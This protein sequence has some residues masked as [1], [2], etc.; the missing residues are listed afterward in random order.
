[1]R[2]C[3]VEDVDL[4][5]FRG[6]FTEQWLHGH[7]YSCQEALF[8]CTTCGPPVLYEPLRGG[9][10]SNGTK[11]SISYSSRTQ[12]KKGSSKSF[13]SALKRLFTSSKGTSKSD[14]TTLAAKRPSGSSHAIHHSNSSNNVA[15]I[16]SAQS[17]QMGTPSL[18]VTEGKDGLPHSTSVE[19]ELPTTPRTEKELFI[20]V[21]CGACY[22]R[23]HASHHHY[24]RRLNATTLVAASGA[25]EDLDNSDIGYPHHSFFF[26]VPSYISTRQNH[27]M[28]E[29]PWGLLFPKVV[30]HEVE[31]GIADLSKPLAFYQDFEEICDAS[32]GV[33]Q[34]NSTAHTRMHSKHSSSAFLE[35]CSTHASHP[36]P[37][38]AQKS[39]HQTS[40]PSPEPTATAGANGG[41]LLKAFGGTGV[42]SPPVFSSAPPDS[43]A[44]LM[45]CAKC[46]DRQTV[47]LSAKNCDNDS[48][49]HQHLRRLGQLTAL[50]AYFLLR[51]VQ[52]ELPKKYLTYLERR[53]RMQLELSR[54]Q[55]RAHSSVE[56]QRVSKLTESIKS[57]DEMVKPLPATS[58]PTTSPGF[59]SLSPTDLDHVL[60]RA[61]LCGFLNTSYF[62]YMNSVLQC[63]LRCRSFTA[64]LMHLGPQGP[65]GELTSDICHLVTHVSKQTYQD[66]KNCAVH[67]F[68]NALRRQIGHLN[69]LF[70]EGEQQD[71]QEF[72][73]TLLNGIADE[74]DKG[75]SDAEKKELRRV[76]FEGALMS[77]AIC[78]KCHHR[79]PRTEMF[80]SLSIPIEKSIEEGVR[81]LFTPAKLTGK[82]CY[83]CETCFQQMP[84]AAQEEHNELA[85]K[86]TEEIKRA[87]AAGKKATKQQ[88]E[89]RVYANCLYEEAEVRTSISHLG[90]SLAVHLLR[91]HYDTEAQDFIKV[92]TPVR[93]S[94]TL[95]LRPYVTDEVRATYERA[96]QVHALRQRFP[97]V[98]RVEL[99]RYLDS[100][101]GGTAEA[102]AAR[103]VEDGYKPATDASTSS[104]Q[105]SVVSVP[106][107]AASPT[108][109]KADGGFEGKG[110]VPSSVSSSGG[111]EAISPSA[112][113]RTS[114]VALSS[115]GGRPPRGREDYTRPSLSSEFVTSLTREDFDPFGDKCSFRP[116]LVRQLVG[117]IAHRGSL[118]G[119]HYIAYVRH[120][121]QPKVWFRCD[122]QDI[123]VVDER[124]VL[125]HEVEVYLAFYE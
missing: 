54:R 60:N 96:D 1:M 15:G 83:A 123:D 28:P 21:T 19:E 95:D 118:H 88:E 62:C 33:G 97:A 59:V 94:E 70:S 104:I 53:R 76:S 31:R 102:A 18:S 111:I 47:R 100:V 7:S 63:L 117:L 12:E 14:L 6:V 81:S 107:A 120:L 40:P 11:S 113:Q 30:V 41:A 121:T 116:T 80:M 22:C 23:D 99:N 125:D 110:A 69:T 44:Y 32:A 106:P 75:K 82:D 55:P 93:I 78:S 39:S 27:A 61:G 49:R 71:A 73:L 4:D 67:P 2:C 112:L 64:P 24:S 10:A 119:G 114:Q 46:D 72:L 77:E 103:L 101:E 8:H 26:G 65:P 52:I 57:V 35:S 90:G 5:I 66:V 92:L 87:K 84:K 13:G 38:A 74:F 50:L 37:H 51:G 86:Q 58:T 56:V 124:Y 98:A 3:C 20:C 25:V 109:S 16:S 91:F 48:P 68:V 43:W 45:L 115:N 79:T 29:T 42:L 85:Q 89:A 122:D 108:S 105:R 36:Q 34:P 9:S 17:Q